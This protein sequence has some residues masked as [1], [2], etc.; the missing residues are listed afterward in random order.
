[1]TTSHVWP[2]YST[3]RKISVAFMLCRYICQL[4]CL[5]TSPTTPPGVRRCE[6]L[7]FGQVQSDRLPRILISI[8]PLLLITYFL[9]AFPNP[10]EPT[11]LHKSL[12]SLPVTSKSSS[13]YPKNYYPEGGY[14]MFPFGRA[15][16]ANGL[17]DHLLTHPEGQI[18]GIG[19]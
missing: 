17:A 18:L 2:T 11:F 12:A 9:T 8:P 7:I 6:S 19:T 1:M 15:R 3:W 14:A 10:L 5:K 4:R 13:I 16:T